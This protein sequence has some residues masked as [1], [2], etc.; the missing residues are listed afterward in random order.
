D[1]PPREALYSNLTV[2]ASDVVEFTIEFRA[3]VLDRTVSAISP[4]VLNGELAK[5]LNG[6]WLSLPAEQRDALDFLNSMLRDTRVSL[7]PA[8]VID[9]GHIKGLGWALVEFNTPPSSGLC[10]CD[11]SAALTV[12]SRACVPRTRITA[13]DAP[14]ILEIPRQT[15]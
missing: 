15:T 14:W 3:F 4:Y 6:N 9:V 2:L 1:L 13:A 11:P 10:A 7:P 12:V 8:V 5:D